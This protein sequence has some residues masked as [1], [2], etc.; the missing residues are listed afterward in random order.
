[1]R[2]DK[3]KENTNIYAYKYIHT[4]TDIK[5]YIN[6]DTHIHINTSCVIQV[7]WCFLTLSFKVLKI[8][9]FLIKSGKLFQI[10]DPI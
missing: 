3:S 6:T 7:R 8:F 4:A 9:A 1:M 2:M 5:A 10:E